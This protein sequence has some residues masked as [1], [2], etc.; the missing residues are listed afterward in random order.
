MALIQS[1]QRTLDAKGRLNLPKDVVEW[2]QEKGAEELLLTAGQDDCVALFTE[3]D[4]VRHMEGMRERALQSGDRSARDVERFMVAY[5]TRC[6]LDKSGRIV[7]PK[8][9]RDRAGLRREVTLLGRLTFVEI[10]DVDRLARRFDDRKAEIEA[11]MQDF[12]P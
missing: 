1:T 11:S 10:W 4:F 9:L 2:L 7:I 12:L 5:A 6:P 8:R 3:E